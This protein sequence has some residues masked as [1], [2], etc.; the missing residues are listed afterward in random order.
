MNITP[1]FAEFEASYAQGRNQVVYARVAADLDTPVSLMLKLA[2]ARP[3]TF[4]LESVTGGEVR[5]RYSVVGMKPDLI[6][7]CEGETVQIN[8]EARLDAD[9]FRPDPAPPLDSLRA[10]IA[11]TRLDVPLQQM[12]RMP[13]AT[14]DTVRLLKTSSSMTLPKSFESLITSHCDRGSP[15]TSFTLA[16]LLVAQ[17]EIQNHQNGYALLAVSNCTEVVLKAKFEECMEMGKSHCIASVLLSGL[18]LGARTPA[19]F[20]ESLCRSVWGCPYPVMACPRE[21]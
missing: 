16:G 4:I 14:M 3:D 2:E 9:A 17:I 21:P 7:R 15:C 11:E 8:R 19:A 12:A 18:S 20:W 10:L 5:G 6:W 13:W 1:T